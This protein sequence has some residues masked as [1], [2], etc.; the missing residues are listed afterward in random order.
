[1]SKQRQPK[2]VNKLPAVLSGAK[3]HLQAKEI[4]TDIL[5]QGTKVVLA[6]RVTYKNK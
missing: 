2:P 6:D 1:M 4:K 3:L 5:K